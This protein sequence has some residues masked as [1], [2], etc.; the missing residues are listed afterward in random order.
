[1]P[2]TYHRNGDVP[3]VRISHYPAKSPNAHHGGVAEPEVPG[4]ES[5]LSYDELIITA[6]IDLHG[7][8]SEDSEA[9]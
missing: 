2:S 6:S 4:L 9:S 7:A 5:D 1:M 3:A 8:E